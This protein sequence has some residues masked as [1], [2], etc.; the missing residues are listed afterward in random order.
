MP[1]SGAASY[2]AK[3]GFMVEEDFLVIPILKAEGRPFPE[4]IGVGRTRGTDI[5]LLSSDVSKYH[6]Y[7][8]VEAE[9]WTITD[10]SSSNGTFVNGERLAPMAPS[11]LEDGALVAFGSHLYQFRTPAGFCSLLGTI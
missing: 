10:A 1:L 9:R 2:A 11:R 5:V 7:F 3:L 6:A 4:R 8:A